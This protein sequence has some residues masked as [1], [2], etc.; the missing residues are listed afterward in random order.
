MQMR[1]YAVLKAVEKVWKGG[2]QNIGA[3]FHS[4]IDWNISRIEIEVK[5]LEWDSKKKYKRKD[6]YTPPDM[7]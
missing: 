7:P 5:K 3:H 2:W 4:F 6:F 1:S